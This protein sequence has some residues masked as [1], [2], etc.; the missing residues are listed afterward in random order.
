MLDALVESEGEPDLVQISGGE[1]TIHPEFFEILDAASARPIRHVMINT[2]GVRIAQEP[3]FVERLASYTPRLRSLSAVRFA[4]RRRA[5]RPARRRSAAHPPAGA[6]GSRS[7][8]ASRRRWSSTVKRGVNDDEI[9]DIVRHALTWNCV[10]GVTF[11]PVQDAGRNDGF[12]AKTDRVLLTEIRRESAS[13][14]CSR[15]TT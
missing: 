3:D 10:R 15:P 9:G 11:Q 14:A 12:D 8:S 1:P 6:G 13:R 7:A 2:N 5:G 4:E